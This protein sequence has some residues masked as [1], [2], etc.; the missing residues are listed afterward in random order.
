MADPFILIAPADQIPPSSVEDTGAT[1]WI[2]PPPDTPARALIDKSFPNLQ[3]SME[4]DN[5]DLIIQLVALG[6][7]HAFVP[8]RALSNFARKKLIQKI[9]LPRPLVRELVVAAPVNLKPS[10]SIEKFVRQILFS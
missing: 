2:L 10:E 9:A 3:V 7:G 1:A 8:R 5:F 6:H 4:I